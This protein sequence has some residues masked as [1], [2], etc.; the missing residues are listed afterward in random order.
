MSAES[1][2]LLV[3][4]TKHSFRFVT[5]TAP[6]GLPHHCEGAPAPVAAQPLAAKAPYGCGVP[7]LRVQSLR[8]D[9]R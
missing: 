2:A 8:F 4:D 5:A 1:S 3:F 7:P 6:F 9:V